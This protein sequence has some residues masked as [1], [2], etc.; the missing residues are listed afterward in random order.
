MKLKCN[1]TGD[2][3][4]V[5]QHRDNCRARATGT[6]KEYRENIHEAKGGGSNKVIKVGEAKQQNKNLLTSWTSCSGCSLLSNID[7]CLK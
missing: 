4:R 1:G 6:R 5:R 7:Y 2:M 3:A